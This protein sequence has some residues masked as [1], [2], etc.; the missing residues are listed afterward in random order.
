[1]TVEFLITYIVI[2]AP[3]FKVYIK[4]MIKIVNKRR[5]I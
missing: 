3:L 5:V 2:M 1:M 4:N